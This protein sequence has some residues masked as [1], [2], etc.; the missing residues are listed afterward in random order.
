MLKGIQERD[1]EHRGLVLTTPDNH[2]HAPHIVLQAWCCISLGVHRKVQIGRCL[3]KGA[4]R[5]F[6]CQQVPRM[7]YGLAGGT[8]PRQDRRPARSAAW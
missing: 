3:R 8:E 6:R 7:E 2:P 4:R 1:R 5:G